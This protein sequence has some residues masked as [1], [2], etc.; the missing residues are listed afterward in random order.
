MKDNEIDLIVITE[1]RHDTSGIEVKGIFLG[2]ITA[3]CNY[4]AYVWQACKD[5]LTKQQCTE[6]LEEHGEPGSWEDWI[7]EQIESTELSGYVVW[8]QEEAPLNLFNGELDDCEELAKYVNGTLAE[9]RA[10]QG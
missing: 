7:A 10:E 6:I 4:D 2:S 8:C 9:T 3:Q 1:N 5:Y